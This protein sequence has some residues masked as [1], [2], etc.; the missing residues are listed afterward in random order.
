MSVPHVA[1]L[2]GINVGKAKRIAMADLRELVEGLGY[3]DVRTLLNSGNV[4][5]G[6][7]SSSSKAAAKAIAEALE[8]E[9]GVSAPV[10]VVTG[11]ELARIV[12][13]NP[14][15]DIAK[16][17]SRLLVTF[18]QTPAQQRALA[19]LAKKRWTP[20]ALAVGKLA[21]YSWCAKGILDSA[22]WPAIERE[23]GKG[24]T[25]RNWATV[26]KLHALAHG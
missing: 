1:L 2:R 3:T 17:P 20:D 21:A 15:L 23:L 26:T 4:V 9:L 18:P 14:L 7:K 22:L 6:A 24:V 13:E 10:T 25:S 19:E 16:D 12:D 8:K 11:A 5:F